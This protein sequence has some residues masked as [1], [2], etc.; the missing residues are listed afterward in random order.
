MLEE[1]RHPV[2]MAM[3]HKIMRVEPIHESVVGQSG[4]QCDMDLN[5]LNLKLRQ[6]RLEIRRKL[7]QQQSCEQLE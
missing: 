1:R 6:D 5:T 7:L 4:G 2:D 3:V